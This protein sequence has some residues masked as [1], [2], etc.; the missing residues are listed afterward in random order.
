MAGLNAG[1]IYE[2]LSNIIFTGNTMG[3]AN[4][5]AATG[6]PGAMV[7]VPSAGHVWYYHVPAGGLPRLIVRVEGVKYQ[8][9][10]DGSIVDLSADPPYFITVKNY[11]VGGAPLTKFEAGRI[12]KVGGEGGLTFKAPDNIYEVPNPRD[13]ELT[14]TVEVIDWVIVVPDAELY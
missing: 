11:I 6:A 9:D 3:D 12:Y 10:A 13:L 2:Q 5:W 1:T 4:D 14:L 8:L 7:S